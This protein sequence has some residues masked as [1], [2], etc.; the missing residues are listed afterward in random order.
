MKPNSTG[1]LMA[2]VDAGVAPFITQDLP[3]TDFPL[4][5]IDLWC[6]F[7]GEHFTLYLPSE[8]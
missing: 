1:V 3:F 6:G 7:D 5:S 8:H 4:E 2:H